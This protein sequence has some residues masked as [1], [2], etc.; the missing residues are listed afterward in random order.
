MREESEKKDTRQPRAVQ[1]HL[2]SRESSAQGAMCE[3]GRLHFKDVWHGG[4][5][6]GTTRK[7]RAVRK[8]LDG[9]PRAVQ[10]HLVYAEAAD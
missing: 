2:Y 8:A 4:L 5:Q 6:A 7:V 9:Q 3:E 10:V 1:V